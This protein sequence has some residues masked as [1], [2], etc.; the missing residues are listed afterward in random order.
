MLVL[1]TATY[2]ATA[3]LRAAAAAGVEV[4]VASEEAP[5]LSGRMVGRTLTLNLADPEESAEKALAFA[6]QWPIDAVIGVDEA[7]VLPAA[8]VAT[9]LGVA[10]N[11]L[12]AVAATRDK[13]QLRAG[14]T[15]AGVPQ[16]AWMEMRWLREAAA[17]DL[18]AASVGLPCVVK[19]VDLSASRGVIR[20]DTVADLAT[21]ME[22]VDRLLCRPELCGSTADRPLLIEAFVPGAEIALEGLL[23]DGELAVLAIF[24]KPDPLNGPHFDET[25]YVTPS[26]QHE[27]LLAEAVTVTRA[28][29]TALGLRD[30][31]IHA[32]LRLSPAGAVFLEVA[33]RS[34]GGRCS[35]A[36]RIRDGEADMSLEELII[37]H[38]CGMQLTAPRLAPGGAGVLMLP[39]PAAGVL[40]RISG[41]ANAGRVPGVEAVEL[42]IPLGHAMEPLPEGDRYLGFVTARGAN[43]AEV[44]TALR[45]AWA[46]LDVIVDAE[47]GEVP[48]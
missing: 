9:R 24:D 11:P 43:A 12:S 39:V 35:S 19:P 22:R 5:T 32:E 6:A 3:F 36:I 33:A 42:T 8:H 17:A 38:A 44:E 15:A 41:L 29:L 21:A 16:P 40:R 30:G 27:G 25:L 1:P 14:L 48:V 31:P 23:S 45:R 7:S 34:I 4:V 28:A 26:R 18:A 47:A 20:A 10:R 2:R 37:R 46:C 13:R